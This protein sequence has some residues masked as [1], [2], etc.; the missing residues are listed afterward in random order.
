MSKEKSLGQYFTPSI[1]AQLMID[2]ISDG[3]KERRIL[4]PSAGKGIFLEILTNMDYRNLTGIEI[5]PLIANQSSFSLHVGNFFDFP[6][7]EKFDIVI[8][9][10]PYIR[11]KN[12]SPNQRQYLSSSSF[13]HKRMSGLTDILQPF[14]FRSV[15]HLKP[16]GELIFITPMFWM[17]T[18]HAEP[19]RRFLLEQGTIELVINFHESRIFPK[20]NLNLIIFKYRKSKQDRFLKVINYWQKGQLRPEIISHIRRLILESSSWDKNS[21]N[22][23]KLEFFETHQPRNSKPWRL[24]PLNIEE[25]LT[26]FEQS[27]HF[28]PDLNINGINVRLSNIYSANDLKALDYPRSSCEELKLGKK[29]YFMAPQ[30]VKLTKFISTGKREPIFPPPR[31]IKVGDIVEI[32]NGMVSGLDKAFRLKATSH[33]TEKEVQLIIPV[34]KAKAIHRY[35]T[36]F[37]TD[38]FLIRPGII[39]SEKILMKDFPSLYAQLE[40]FKSALENRYQYNKEIPYWEWV[41]IRNYNL[42]KE[43]ESLICVPCKDRFDT[44]GHL[45]FTLC[46]KGI[47]ATQDVTVL[48]KFSWVKESPEYITAFLNSKEVFNWVTNKGLIR[49]GVV[50]FSEEPLKNIPFRLINWESSTERQIHQEVKLLVQKIQ[51]NKVEDENK[52]SEVNYLISQLLKQ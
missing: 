40:P 19:L 7:T 10:P 28:S 13:W 18:L 20:V 52:I 4:E 22:E 23:G 48:V 27:C 50:E 35:Y 1:V 38:Y 24:L 51:E 39:Q 45:R 34:V 29:K 26:K 41:F 31:F 46:K 11:W 14:I 25:E 30:R 44:R 6:I 9:N 3:S 47:F 16:G 12:L 42:M 21:K 36:E 49:G 17:Q 37:L 32:G 33:L 43:A 15:D 8:G 5:D 2:L